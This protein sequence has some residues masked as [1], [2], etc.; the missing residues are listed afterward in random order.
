MGN[1]TNPFELELV[2]SPSADS[3]PRDAVVDVEVPEPSRLDSPP[4]SPA[5]DI[6]RGSM[7]VGGRSCCEVTEDPVAAGGCS[8]CKVCDVELGWPFASAV[9]EIV[10]RLCVGV[11][12]PRIKVDVLVLDDPSVDCS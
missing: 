8:C 3:A 6:D 11:D 2:V 12:S 1:G 5:C 7:V 4:L 9:L 10:E